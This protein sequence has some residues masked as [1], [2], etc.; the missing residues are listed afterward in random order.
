MAGC[1]AD[2][3]TDIL[4]SFPLTFFNSSNLPLARFTE[5]KLGNI[6][7]FSKL[8][9]GKHL[10]KSQ[11]SYLATN[12]TDLRSNQISSYCLLV[13]TWQH[14][15]RRLWTWQCPV[16]QRQLL[17]FTP[18]N[19]RALED[20]IPVSSMIETVENIKIERQQTTIRTFSQWGRKL[21]IYNM[22]CIIHSY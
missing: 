13:Q 3:K 2:S 1:L 6:I 11:T 5:F 22:K 15:A 12:H 18:Q 21:W 4:T 10:F 20:F 8:S 16:V 9:H 7:K 14:I 19:Q 17:F